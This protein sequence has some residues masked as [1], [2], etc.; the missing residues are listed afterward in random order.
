MAMYDPLAQFGYQ[1]PGLQF[2]NSGG[3]AYAPLAGN[4]YQQ[5]PLVGTTTSM[6]PNGQMLGGA[7]AAAA[8]AGGDWLSKD[9]MFGQSGWV[10]PAVGIAS[11]LLQGFMGMQNYGLAK[12]QLALQR[13]AYET[14]TANQ[15]KLVNSQLEDR[16]RARVA[17]NS[18]AYQSVSDYMRQNGI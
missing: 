13:E 1:S 12:E 16:Q 18:G 8:G 10:S 15:K 4:V 5:N 9:G 11:G 2:G 7:N 14:N 6:L 3:Q 17:S